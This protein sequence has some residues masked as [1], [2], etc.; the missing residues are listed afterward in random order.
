MDSL[1]IFD[2]PLIG[3]ASADDPLFDELK[4]TAIVGPERLTPKEWIGSARSVISYFL[5]FTKRVREAKQALG[6]ACEGMGRADSESLHPVQ[7][8]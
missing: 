6:V 4:V 2:Q 7:P 3:V 1:R 8:D 5:P